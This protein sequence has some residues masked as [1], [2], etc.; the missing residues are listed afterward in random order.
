MAGKLIEE[1]RQVNGG[2]WLGKQPFLPQS[3]KAKTFHHEEYE[4]TPESH[5]HNERHERSRH[6]AV[7]TG[8][9]Y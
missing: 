1:D 3:T 4:G 9:L 8:P 5:F 6:G 7:S 2:W